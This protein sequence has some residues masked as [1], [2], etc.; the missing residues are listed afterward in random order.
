MCTGVA[1]ASNFTTWKD[2]K[3][4]ANTGEH[5]FADALAGRAVYCLRVRSAPSTDP[6]Q[7]LAAYRASAMH[8]AMVQLDTASEGFFDGTGFGPGWGWG[9]ASYAERRLDRVLGFQTGADGRLTCP[10]AYFGR[11]NKH[12]RRMR[13]LM[14]MEHTVNH[15]VW[16]LLHAGWEFDLGF[17][18][19][20]DEKA[21]ETRLKVAYRSGH[22]GRLPPLMDR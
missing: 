14:C 16:A 22:A 5:G 6:R 7:I 1:F 10:I 15:A 18:A 12:W 9:Y 3:A 20:A 8:S 13:E 11:S 19:S 17:A 4:A 21:E 2:F